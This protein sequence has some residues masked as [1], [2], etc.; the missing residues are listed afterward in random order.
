M[1]EYLKHFAH[2]VSLDE[3]SVPLDQCAFLIAAHAHSQLDMAHELAK[4][5]R[6]AEEVPTPDLEGILLHLFQ[7]LGFKGDHVN[8]Y[9]PRNSYLSDVLH[10]RRGIP[11]SLS[12]LTIEVSK[13][14]G[15]LLD[16]VSMPGHFLLRD[17]LEPPTFIDP[18]HRGS[19]LSASEC[20]ELFYRTTLG[21]KD[22]SDEFLEPVGTI[23]ILERMLANLS[24]IHY[25][26]ADFEEMRWVCDLTSSL[27][28][29]DVEA[30]EPLVNLCKSKGRFEQAS[31]VRKLQASRCDDEQQKEKF[32]R[33]SILLLTFLN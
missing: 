21:H 14:L 17:K 30:Y 13:R 10:R 11:I 6:L 9:D 19:V 15:V 7:N 31:S 22:F 16:G 28:S 20:E 8:Y 26:K 27:P 5:D 25:A 3:R 2:L 23:A 33:E 32:E 12:A 29:R 1:A 24:A 18:F 4:L